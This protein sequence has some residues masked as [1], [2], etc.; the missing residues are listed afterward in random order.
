MASNTNYLKP[1][2]LIIGGGVM[3]LWLLNDLQNAGYS[4]LLLEHREVGGGQTLHS[5]SY[6]HQGT[7][8]R[9]SALIQELQTVRQDWDTWLT[10]RAPEYGYLPSY[11]GFVNPA[12]AEMRKV[13]WQSAGLT[14]EHSPLPP[15]LNRGKIQVLLKSPELCLNGEWLI[16][17]L[18]SRVGEFAT[19]SKAVNAIRINRATDRVEEVHVSLE[20]S[21][22]VIFQP[23]TLVLAAG[24]GNQM[25]LE[26]A[27]SGHRPYL[28]RV[29]DAQQIRKAFMLVI[30]GKKGDLEPLT[31]IF[32]DLRGLFIVSRELKEENGVIWL[33][34]DYTSMGIAFI[35]DWMTYDARWW[36]EGV[37]P[38]LQE[39][40]PRVMDNKQRLR[41][42]VYAAPKAEGKAGGFLPN[43][44]RIE[45]F[46]FRN[47]W[48]VWPTKLTLAPKASRL[49]VDRIRECVPDP[50]GWP[51]PPEPWQRIRVPVKTAPERWRKTP[52]LQWHEFQNCY[53]EQN[54]FKQ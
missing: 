53:L 8:Y 10:G 43:D 18:V 34:S 49:L 51:T 9:E 20:S 17:E 35:E 6:I 1:D 21:K 11:I 27:S 23:R 36:L 16:S 29:G 31:G 50:G 33:V 41:W 24:A 12:D 15:V 52:L 26:L 48:A 19:R 3:G 40:A 42:G 37:L 14:P 13:L 32:P 7:T 39:L 45:D 30:E 2:V 38:A 25:L 46:R 22:E 47:L 44:P 4:A 54:V 5:H 28:G